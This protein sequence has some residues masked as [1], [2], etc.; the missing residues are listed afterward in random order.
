MM[1]RIMKTGVVAVALAASALLAAPANAQVNSFNR[2]GVSAAELRGGPGFAGDFRRSGHVTQAKFG[3]A[4]HVN[5]FGQTPQEVQ[6]LIDDA[7]YQCDCQ[8]QLDASYQGFRAAEL[9]RPRVEQIG[10]QKFVVYSK[11]RLLD[12]RKVDR[13]PYECKV[14]R[15]SIRASTDLYPARFAG[16]RGHNFRNRGITLSFNTGY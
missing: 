5:A 7:I 3:K 12:G 14:A 6:Y 15:G 4:I 9:R 8:L 16:F 13:Q 11:A 2:G 1:K 10:K